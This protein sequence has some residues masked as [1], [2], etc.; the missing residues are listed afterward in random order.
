MYIARFLHDYLADNFLPTTLP[1]D[2]YSLLSD[3]L[4]NIET[5]QDLTW[6]ILEESKLDKAVMAVS[7]R[8]DSVQKP[9]V[10]EPFDLQK[11]FKALNLHWAT[12]AQHDDRPQS[13]QDA[14][15]T[16]LIPPLLKAQPLDVN[17]AVDQALMGKPQLKESITEIVMTPEQH[18]SSELQ[19]K[20]YLGTRSYKVSYLRSHPPRPMG[21]APV[22]KQ[23]F[24]LRNSWDKVFT[25]G[26]IEAGRSI[27]FSQLANNDEWRP[28]YGSLDLQR[29]PWTWVQPGNEEGVFGGVTEEMSDLWMVS[30]DERRA[31]QVEREARVKAWQDEVRPEREARQKEEYEML[32]KKRKEEALGQEKQDL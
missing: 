11:R 30:I 31:R 8:R 22:A 20:Y 1:T 27:A 10:D 25:D 18:V 9:L 12:L 13:W 15:D 16:V 21:Y 4:R 23:P 32:E 14:F 29:V 28:I 2:N 17:G 5:R 19:F 7:Q 3:Y 26:I 6:L 24:A